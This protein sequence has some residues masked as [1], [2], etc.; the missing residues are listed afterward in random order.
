MKNGMHSPEDNLR[1]LGFVLPPVPAAAGNYLPWR[2]HGN[3]LML[4]GVLCMRE[5][6]ITHS[7]LVGEEQTVESAYEAA[8]V[9]A[10]NALAVIREA[11]GSL[12]AV[13]ELLHLT[14]YV[15]AVPRFAESPRVVNGASDLF[16]R[17]FGEAGKHA[18]AAV[19]VTGLPRNAT[20]EL[21]VT[22]CARS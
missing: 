15:A 9:C 17:V 20:V 21:S 22:L 13:G 2:R 6:S 16:A 19:A 11:L 5:G 8:Q 10:L 1:Q 3:L 4:S 12:S 14:G 7:G 18:R